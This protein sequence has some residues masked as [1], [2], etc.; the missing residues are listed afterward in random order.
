MY[1]V[2]ILECADH[3]L[4]VGVTNN[5]ERRVFEHNF[6]ARGA[7]YTK[8]RRPVVLRYQEKRLTRGDA[9]RREYEIKSL[10]REEKLRL[11]G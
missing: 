1:Y 8:A 11:V 2:Y 5:V 6:S 7:R 3:T 4:Y 9:L 10:T